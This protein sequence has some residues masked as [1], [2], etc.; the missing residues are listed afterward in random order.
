VYSKNRRTDKPES[1]RSDELPALR[2]Q[3]PGSSKNPV[4]PQLQ[5]DVQTAFQELLTARVLVVLIKDQCLF[6]MTEID[7]FEG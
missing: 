7:L 6:L 2:T 5:I 3:V 4:R 1:L